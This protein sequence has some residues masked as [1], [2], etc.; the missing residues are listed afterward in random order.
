MTPEDLAN[1]GYMGYPYTPY[2]T[3][4]A[5]PNFKG[6]PNQ[7]PMWQ[8]AEIQKA[9]KANGEDPFLLAAVVGQESGFNPTALNK[10]SGA[11]GLGQ[12]T[13]G[14][15]KWV[16]QQMG[17]KNPNL[18]DPQTNLDMRSWLDAYNFR[19]YG[20]WQAA[21]AHSGTGAAYGQQAV[22]IELQLDGNF[23]LKDAQGN[24]ISMAD[25]T[26]SAK[27]WP[28]AAPR[29]PVASRHPAPSPHTKGHHSQ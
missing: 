15:A 9:A 5:V 6:Q 26:A 4:G 3:Y 25:Y 17:L 29:K 18:F 23:T 20:S 16:A 19:K 11:A 2:N 10:K 8:W 7:L 21:E 13:P 27:H 28:S 14:T 24:T 1:S 22:K 12:L